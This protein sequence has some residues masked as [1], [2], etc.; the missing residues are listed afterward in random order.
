MYNFTQQLGLSTGSE[1]RCSLCKSNSEHYFASPATCIVQSNKCH[2]IPVFAHLYTVLNLFQE[3]I[4]LYEKK[5]VANIRFKIL[6]ANLK[7]M[8]SSSASK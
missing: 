6:V 1:K 3:T 4:F 2:A 7:K 5:T 8:L